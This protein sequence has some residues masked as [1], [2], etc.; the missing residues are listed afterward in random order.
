MIMKVEKRYFSPAP[1]VDSAI[2]A[3]KNISRRIF[4]KNK[5]NEEKFWKIVKMGFAHKRKKLSGNL[6]SVIPDEKLSA[7]GLKNQR[8]E[9]LSLTDWILLAKN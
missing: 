3:I 1:K 6:K 2:I 8:A 4:E 9:D 5:I 7:M